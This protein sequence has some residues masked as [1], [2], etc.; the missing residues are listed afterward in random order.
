MSLSGKALMKREL[1]CKEKPLIMGV[2][3]VTPDSF[4][5][6]GRFFD[7]DKAVEHALR[8]VEE[9]ADIIDVGGESTRPY[10]EP[11]PADEELKRV[12]PV[13]SGIRARSDILISVDTYKAKTARAAHDAGADMINDISGLTFDRD[14]AGTVGDLGAYVVIVHI[15]GTPGNMQE[16]PFY[17]DVISEIKDFFVGR[18]RFAKDRGIK[19]DDIILD[20]GI[21]FGKRVEDNLKILKMLGTFKDVGRPVLAG[22]SMKSFIGTVTEATMEERIDGTLASIAISLWN[23]ADIVRVHDVERAHRVLNLVR[24]VRGS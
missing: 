17:D 1:R 14:M 20:P 7:V 15:K 18:V 10:S 23:G 22:A 9:G 21:G 24:A 6:G 2:L 4:F 13:I 5:D 19:E 3:N 8:M 11:V 16:A 12:L